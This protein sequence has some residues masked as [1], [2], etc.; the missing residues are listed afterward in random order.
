M[1]YTEQAICSMHE[2]I[3]N[4]PIQFKSVQNFTIF[5]LTTVVLQQVVSQHVIIQK[6]QL[7]FSQASIQSL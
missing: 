4:L 1:H 5:T 2:F 3:R 6:I 7:A